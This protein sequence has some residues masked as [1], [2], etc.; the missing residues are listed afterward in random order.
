MGRQLK[1]EGREGAHIGGGPDGGVGEALLWATRT[2]MD[3]KDQEKPRAPDARRVC[4]SLEQGLPLGVVLLPRNPGQCLE[5]C[6]V[7]I[8]GLGAPVISWAE[9]RD[10]AACSIAAPPQR[11]TSSKWPGPEVGGGGCGGQDDSG[12]GEERAGFAV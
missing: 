6:L 8:N 1:V 4:R 11:R 12:G 3:T 9:A 10:A 5:M 2:A 7:V